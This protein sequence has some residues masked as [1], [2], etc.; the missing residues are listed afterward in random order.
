MD[1][2]QADIEDFN[3]KN[4]EVEITYETLQRSLRSRQEA[5][6][7][8]EHGIRIGKKLKGRLSEH[9]YLEEE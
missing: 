2:I 7:E 8:T 1:E 4:P 6:A 9:R 3:Q 5:E